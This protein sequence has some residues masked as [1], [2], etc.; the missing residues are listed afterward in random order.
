MAAATLHRG[1]LAA[2]I[3]LAWE[4]LSYLPVP[5]E[6]CASPCAVSLSASHRGHVLV[7]DHLGIERLATVR[8]PA[9]G[10]MAGPADV[11]VRALGRPLGHAR[12]PQVD[13]F[14]VQD[15]L[16]IGDDSAPLVNRKRNVRPGRPALVVPSGRDG[17]QRRAGSALPIRPRGCPQGAWVQ[18]PPEWAGTAT[19][20]SARSVR[21]DPRSGDCARSRIPCHAQPRRSPEG[22]CRPGLETV[23]PSHGRARSPARGCG[24]VELAGA[25]VAAGAPAPTA[26][27]GARAA[28]G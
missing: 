15:V 19:R 16:V 8:R 28:L 23:P 26:T 22:Y 2:A 10:Q 1:G 18:I 21:G 25:G 13:R 9:R 3:S 14:G 24:T 12:R 17:E 6:P 27:G 20:S 11:R 7:L 4:R 5:P